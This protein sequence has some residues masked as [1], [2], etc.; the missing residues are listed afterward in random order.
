[1]YLGWFDGNPANL[2]PL[3]APESA[4][5]YVEWMGGADE[6]IR[7]GAAV[8]V[9]GKLATDDGT[10]RAVSI[11]NRSARRSPRPFTGTCSGGS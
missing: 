3:P 8:T 9:T 2:N 5:R 7:K 10:M 6:V 1:M 4:A 11:R